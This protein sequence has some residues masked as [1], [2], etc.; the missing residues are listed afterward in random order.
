MPKL[1]VANVKQQIEQFTYWVPGSP[2]Y[3]TQEIPI[4]GQIL[5][6]GKDLPQGVVDGIVAQHRVYGILP[7]SEALTGRVQYSG[8]CYSIDRPVRYDHLLQLVN[9][10]R[11]IL[12]D[13]GRKLREEAAIA[14]DDYINQQ[15]FSQQVPGRLENLEMS[16]EEVSRDQRDETPEVS[17]GV[18]VSRAAQAA[19]TGRRAGR[20]MRQPLRRGA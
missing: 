19:A 7:A 18:R 12:V 3:F 4:G 20:G 11:T 16:V 15:L 1:Y 17:E 13:R 2:R 6:A 8:V 5:V 14:T 10:Y 9:G